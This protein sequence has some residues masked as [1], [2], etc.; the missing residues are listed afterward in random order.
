MLVLVHFTMPCFIELESFA[1]VGNRFIQSNCLS[2]D[3]NVVN[4][5]HAEVIAR[6]AF[7][8]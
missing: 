5:A 8:R 7:V 3:G 4:D 6:R 2:L 1:F